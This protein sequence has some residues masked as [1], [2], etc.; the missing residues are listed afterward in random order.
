[1]FDFGDCHVAAEAVMRIFSGAACD[2]KFFVNFQSSR[3]LTYFHLPTLSSFPSSFQLHLIPA[4]CSYFSLLTQISKYTHISLYLHIYIS[5]PIPIS[6]SRLLSLSVPT[7][8]LAIN[9]CGPN[10]SAFSRCG[11]ALYD[12]YYLACILVIINCARD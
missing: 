9:L 12:V 5:S 7:W 10:L 4:P 1:M 2:K 8:N 11:S 6:Y 3:L